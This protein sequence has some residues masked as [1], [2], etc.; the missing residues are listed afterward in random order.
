MSPNIAVRSDSWLN[1]SQ[2]VDTCC[3]VQRRATRAPLEHRHSI[4]AYYSFSEIKRKY[5]LELERQKQGRREQTKQQPPL[6]HQSQQ[7]L[8]SASSDAQSSGQ[9]QHLL[10]RLRQESFHRHRLGIDANIS[11]STCTITTLDESNL[12]NSIELS[13]SLRN[14]A[15]ESGANSD[16]I[17]GDTHARR[18]TC[19]TDAARKRPLLM[20]EPMKLTNLRDKLARSG[21]RRAASQQRIASS[22][23]NSNNN[24]TA[25]ECNLHK[26]QQQQQQQ[27]TTKVEQCAS[28][29][30]ARSWSSLG[31][32][33]SGQITHFR[34]SWKQFLYEYNNSK[35]Q[36][37]CD[38]ATNTRPGESI[39]FGAHEEARPASGARYRRTGE[40]V[41][42]HYYNR[43]SADSQR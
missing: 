11:T 40:W 37:R 27:K 8:S 6:R 20:R 14:D 2:A 23:S 19:D 18:V 30:F 39:G 34:H 24:N 41:E 36:Q 31:V 10:I 21:A 16:P 38:A 22:H 29:K 17:I 28:G 33:L 5:E 26:Q 15:L 12:S 35:L 4:G 25:S 32:R 43:R 3:A 7:N 1:L 9:R 42:R 13:A